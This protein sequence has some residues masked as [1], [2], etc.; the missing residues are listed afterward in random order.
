MYLIEANYVFKHIVDTY[1]PRLDKE[2]FFR[3]A[4]THAQLLDLLFLDGNF[5]G[6]PEYQVL[7]R[8]FRRNILKIIRNPYISSKR[9]IAMAIFQ[10]SIPLYKKLSLRQWEKSQWVN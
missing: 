9:K 6:G 1:F 4:W 10:V 3:L 2:M 7:V 5:E 8:F